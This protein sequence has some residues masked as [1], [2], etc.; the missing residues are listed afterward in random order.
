MKLYVIS[1][2]DKV[3]DILIY[4]NELP[5]FLIEE[6]FIIQLEVNENKYLKNVI[7]KYFGPLNLIH[8]YLVRTAL[9]AG[10]QEI[11]FT[12]KSYQV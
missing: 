7:P 4:H 8:E 2:G 10:S 3:I 1:I 9:V 6:N 12:F 5:I 11:K